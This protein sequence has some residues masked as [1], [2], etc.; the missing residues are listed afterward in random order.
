[1]AQTI[2]LVSLTAAMAVATVAFGWWAV[3]VVAAVWGVLARAQRGS[4]LLAGLSAMLAWAALLGFDA[5]RGPVGSLA[6]T[7]GALLKITSAGALAVT[8]ALP[9]LLAL[10]AAI[11]AR[12][13]ASVRR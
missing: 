3:P 8:L 4:A 7:L 10:T 13:I 5:A 6:T 9:G 1:M 2:R 12:S 11:V